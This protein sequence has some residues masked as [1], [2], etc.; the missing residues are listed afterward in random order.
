MNT[1]GNAVN[2][3]VHVANATGL[4]FDNAGK[5]INPWAGIVGLSMKTAQELSKNETLGR[6]CNTARGI[7][8]GAAS[9]DLVLGS[10]GV[11]T[12]VGF[13]ETAIDAATIWALYTDQKKYTGATGVASTISNTIDSATELLAVSKDKYQSARQDYDAISKQAKDKWNSTFR[14]NE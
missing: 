9:L 3:L 2:Y 12:G 4:F 1:T 7:A 5:Y 10:I 11:F 14:Q 6:V 13:V 8:I